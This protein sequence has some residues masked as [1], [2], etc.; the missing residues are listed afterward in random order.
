MKKWLIFLLLIPAYAYAA[1]LQ[2]PKNLTDAFFSSVIKGNI[3]NAYDQLFQGS[4]IPNDKPQAVTA[5]KQQTRSN[6]PLYGKLLGY[7]FIKEEKFGN[8][9]TRILYI[10]KS[11]KGPTIWEFYFYK[12]ENSWF[13]ANVVFNDQ[14]QMLR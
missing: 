6:L 13:L 3:S 8:S 2:T 14:F 9:V 11:E 10:L 5:L 7:E 4:S 1:D 12:P